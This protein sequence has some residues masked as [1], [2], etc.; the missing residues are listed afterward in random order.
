MKIDP[1]AEPEHTTCWADAVDGTT[2]PASSV[3]RCWA[4]ESECLSPEFNPISLIPDSTRSGNHFNLDDDGDDGP[5]YNI[6][7]GN[8]PRDTDEKAVEDFFRQHRCEVSTVRLPREDP[9]K[10]GGK[11]RSNIKGFGYVEFNDNR[12]FQ[13]ALKCNGYNMKGMRI[14]VDKDDRPLQS[15]KGGNKR[16]AAP[17]PQTSS[18]GKQDTSKSNSKGSG[19]NNMTS[20]GRGRTNTRITNDWWDTQNWSTSNWDQNF[21]SN[22]SWNIK[23]DNSSH[24]ASGGDKRGLGQQPIFNAPSHSRS[25]VQTAGRGGGTYNPVQSGKGSSGGLQ[26]LGATPL[27]Q[28]KSRTVDSQPGNPASSSEAEPTRKKVDPFGGAKPRDEFEYLKK[29]ENEEIATHADSAQS[30]HSSP[31]LVQ[32]QGGR[33]PQG[34]QHHAPPPPPPPTQHTP[35][36]NSNNYNDWDEDWNGWDESYGGWGDSKRHAKSSGRGTSK[37]KKGKGGGKGRGTGKQGSQG[38]NASTIDKNWRAR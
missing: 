11:G 22:S 34:Q 28:L 32:N 20:V 5:P 23:N 14:K 16:S 24:I 37:G 19:K 25:G 21:N 35:V 26:S 33:T 6:Y 4:D 38:T 9:K 30:Y 7:V 12:S 3:R 8:L 1:N 27:Q 17:P 18:W 31:S 36:H 15:K 10:G 29:K 13:N 2:L